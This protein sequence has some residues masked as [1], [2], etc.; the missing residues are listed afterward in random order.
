MVELG[1]KHECL[2]CGTKFYDLG[3]SQLICP[4]CEGDQAELAKELG[5]SPK[6]KKS[7]V[8]SKTR[9]KKSK[10]KAKAPKKAAKKKKKAD[11]DEEVEDES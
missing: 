5:D 9:A 7:K 10:P 2:N 1:N 4:S 8:K 3:K 6:A 11:G